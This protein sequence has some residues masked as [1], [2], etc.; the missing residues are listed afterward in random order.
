MR[1]LDTRLSERTVRLVPDVLVEETNTGTSFLNRV[2]I[3]QQCEHINGSLSDVLLPNQT[4][5]TQQVKT[6]SVWKW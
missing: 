1:D 5:K 6:V 4:D 2:Q 3:S